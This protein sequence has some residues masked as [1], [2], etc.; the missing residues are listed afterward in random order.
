[1]DFKIWTLKNEENNGRRD[2]SGKG[3]KVMDR[4]NRKQVSY[5]NEA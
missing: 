4:R 3:L 5:T 2:E 1:M